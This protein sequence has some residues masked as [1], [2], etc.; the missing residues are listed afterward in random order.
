[1]LAQNNLRYS[2]QNAAGQN[3]NVLHKLQMKSVALNKIN[4]ISGNSN[5]PKFGDS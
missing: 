2:Q 4:E 3:Q 1:M 5:R